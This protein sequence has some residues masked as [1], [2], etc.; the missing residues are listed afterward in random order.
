[1]TVVSKLTQSIPDGYLEEDHPP[2][3]VRFIQRL[4]NQH[5][6]VATEEQKATLDEKLKS[7]RDAAEH[8]PADALSSLRQ[9]PLAQWTGL[10]LNQYMHLY[11]PEMAFSDLIMFVGNTTRAH[12]VYYSHERHSSHNRLAPP[13]RASSP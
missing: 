2:G 13:V 12:V 4:W 6:V 9:K 8:S 5:E 3:F 7:R 10:D 11:R 1:V